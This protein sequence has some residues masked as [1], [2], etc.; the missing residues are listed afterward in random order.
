MQQVHLDQLPETFEQTLGSSFF[1]RH[2][3]VLNYKVTIT[4][5]VNDHFFH[6]FFSIHSPQP[7]VFLASIGV[8][9]WVKDPSMF[10]AIDIKIFLVLSFSQPRKLKMIISTRQY[11]ALSFQVSPIEPL[12]A[13]H[14]FQF[15]CKIIEWLSPTWTWQRTA[16]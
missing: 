13:A 12:L 9:V 5:T 10:E 16:L 6:F 15:Y 7:N 3:E 8:C 4:Y 1:R 11:H 14:S 2:A